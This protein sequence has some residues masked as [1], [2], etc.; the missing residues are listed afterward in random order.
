MKRVAAL[1]TFRKSW[2]SSTYEWITIEVKT[3]PVIYVCGHE[4]GGVLGMSVTLSLCASSSFSFFSCAVVRILFFFSHPDGYKTFFDDS[5]NT[6][7]TT[8]KRWLNDCLGFSFFPD[9]AGYLS[10]RQTD[11]KVP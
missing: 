7:R 3:E 4:S 5:E 8:M 2:T 11:A 1:L 6:L 10:F 9:T